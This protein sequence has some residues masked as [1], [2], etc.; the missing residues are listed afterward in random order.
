MSSTRHGKA[1]VKD[2]LGLSKNQ[3]D[4][5]GE[6]AWNHGLKHGECKGNLSK[7][8]DSLYFKYGG[9][10]NVYRVYAHHVYVFTPN[11]KLVTV[12]GL[13]NNLCALADKLTKARD[14]EE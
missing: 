2:R 6:R 8:I 11:G 5:V 9:N 12:M 13:P 10:G 4:K 1:R 7:Y 14:V 3:A